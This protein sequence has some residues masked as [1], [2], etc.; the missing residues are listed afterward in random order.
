MA[1]EILLIEDTDEIRRGIQLSL[2][3]KAIKSQPLMKR[4]LL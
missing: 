2:Q 3:K 1:T 4:K